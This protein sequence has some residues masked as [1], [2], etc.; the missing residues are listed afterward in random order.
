MS[1]R[2]PAGPLMAEHRVIERMLAVLEGQLDVIARTRSVDPLLIDAA[3]DFIRTYADRCHH[4]K[5]EDILF[6]ELDKKPLAPEHR[7]VMD[8]LIAEHREG[9]R[10]VGELRSAAAAY[11]GG[12][13]RELEAVLDRLEAL[14]AFYPAHISKE[15]KAFFLP[16]MNYLGTEEREAMLEEERE[17]DREFIHELYRERMAEAVA[18]HGIVT[19]GEARTGERGET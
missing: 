16:S 11:E 3:T 19:G 12:D 13:G 4:G 17:F 6:R 10:M 15:D 9:R 18:E 14:A 2:S 5:E 1:G 7:A 8:E